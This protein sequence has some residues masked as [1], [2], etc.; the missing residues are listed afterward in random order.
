MDCLPIPSL[1]GLLR[2][3]LQN[4]DFFQD[5]SSSD[6]LWGTETEYAGQTKELNSYLQPFEASSS[7]PLTVAIPIFFI[8]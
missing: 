4:L 2:R 1:R 7:N 6:S 8:F 5:N 3:W